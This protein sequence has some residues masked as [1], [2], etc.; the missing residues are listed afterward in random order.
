M[1]QLTK[2]TV[3]FSVN[4]DADNEEKWKKSNAQT[5]CAFVVRYKSRRS[6]HLKPRKLTNS[7]RTRSDRCCI[8]NS[9]CDHVIR[10]GSSRLPCA[11]SDVTFDAY[12][13]VQLGNAGAYASIVFS[14]FSCP[15]QMMIPYHVSSHM[16]RRAKRTNCFVY[17]Y[18]PLRR[19]DAASFRPTLTRTAST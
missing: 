16:R 14:N 3:F 7:T 8:L 5:C 12:G 13:V 4:I 15:V 19:N 17:L 11:D 10:S 2:R 6:S 18:V 9:C 1:L